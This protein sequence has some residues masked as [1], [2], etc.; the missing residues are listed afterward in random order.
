MNMESQAAKSSP[1][2]VRDLQSPKQDWESIRGVPRKRILIS[3][4]KQGI[5]NTNRNEQSADTRAA[6][7]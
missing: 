5:V 6:T 3:P 1:N 2:E 7:I 4:R